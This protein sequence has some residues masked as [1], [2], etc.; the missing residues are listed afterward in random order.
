[1]CLTVFSVEL[2]TIRGRTSLIEYY[3]HF[4]PNQSEEQFRDAVSQCAE[5]ACVEDDDGFAD[6]EAT[7]IG[8]C[9]VFDDGNV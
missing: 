2:S 3:D 7:C 1:L 5:I 4:T 9:G 8:W 6:T